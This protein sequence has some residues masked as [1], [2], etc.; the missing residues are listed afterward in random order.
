VKGLQ[1]EILG[2][3]KE[4]DEEGRTGGDYSNAV[5]SG[6]GG[7]KGRGGERGF[8]M[9]QLARVALGGKKK[10]DLLSGGGK[11]EGGEN[12]LAQ[13]EK[14]EGRGKI[15]GSHQGLAK[16]DETNLANKR[17]RK[18]S[19]KGHSGKGSCAEK[20]HEGLIRG[21]EGTVPVAIQE[22]KAK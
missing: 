8:P 10:D 16:G 12:G 5:L 9:A 22:T 20:N 21:E 6:G 2:E 11:L 7:E 14:F 19:R 3:K 1:G 4:R 15:G 13:G 17:G 18:H